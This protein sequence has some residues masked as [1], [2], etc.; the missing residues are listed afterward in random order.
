V[1]LDN[2]DDWVERAGVM[3]RAAL[4]G[5]AERFGY[6]PGDN[7]I[8]LAAA[9]PAFGFRLPA[10]DLADFFSV[11]EEVS[12]PDIW[13]GYFLGPATSVVERLQDGDPSSV[14]IGSEVH[15]AVFI[16]SDGGGAYFAVDATAGGAV[17]HVCEGFIEQGVLQGD[18]RVVAADLNDFLEALLEN[19]AAVAQGQA[20]AF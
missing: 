4:E 11:V 10:S 5:F 2:L 19:V 16:G 9:A 7:E 3:T 17:L 13:N 8:R 18:V 6:D 15:R 14:L 1:A 20:P 12:W